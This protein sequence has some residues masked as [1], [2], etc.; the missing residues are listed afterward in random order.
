MSLQAEERP[1][2]IYFS[3]PWGGN[4][5]YSLTQKSLSFFM[6]GLNSKKGRGGMIP[7]EALKCSQVET[8]CS[9]NEARLGSS[10]RSVLAQGRGLTDFCWASSFPVGAGMVSE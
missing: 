1:P 6:Q 9:C 10:N 8:L 2:A 4:M 5:I 7:Q 3:P